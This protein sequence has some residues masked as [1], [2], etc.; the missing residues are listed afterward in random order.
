M[1]FHYRELCAIN[2]HELVTSDI[3]AFGNY[4]VDLPLCVP[5]LF[6]PTERDLVAP[7]L[8]GKL[9]PK[10]TVGVSKTVKPSVQPNQLSRMR[11]IWICVPYWQS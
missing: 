10:W 8:T 1:F 3:E 6:G 2:H 7:Q 4:T 9:L 11:I 5:A